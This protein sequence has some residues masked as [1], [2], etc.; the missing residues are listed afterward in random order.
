MRWNNRLSF[1][2]PAHDKRGNFRMKTILLAGAFVA[3]IAAASPAAAVNLIVNGS[4]EAAGTTGTGAYT[5]WT[6]TNVP[7]NAPT[8]VIVYNS[9]ASYPVSAF[10]EAV[11]PDNAVSASPDAVGNYAA[12]FVGDFST[13]EA[14]SQLTRLEVG[15]YRLGFSFY[16]TANGL[17]NV[18][19]S[20]FAATIIGTPVTMTNINSQSLGQTWISV[21]GVG[22][23]SARGK[24]DTS[25][26]FNSAGNPSKD[27]VIDRVFAIPTTDAATVFIPPTPT[28]AIPE[29]ATWAL[30]VVGFGMVG[31]STRRRNRTV[32]A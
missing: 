27:I 2:V 14:I 19:N 3:A 31:L 15:N 11:T 7:G 5:G 17:A 26:V 25:F 29:P 1:G 6:K 23:I 18:G 9:T 4:F 32:V 28:G 21:S 24:Y 20:T 30:L 12:Y 22:N 8:S 13:N 16:L 10:G